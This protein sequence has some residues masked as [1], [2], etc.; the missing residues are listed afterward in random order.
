MATHPNTIHSQILRITHDTKSPLRCIIFICR[1]RTKQSRRIFTPRDNQD[2]QLNGNIHITCASIKL[3]TASAA[4]TE[5]GALFLNAQEARI[6][7]LILLELLHPQPP[8]PVHVDN[9]TVVGIV[10]NAIRCQRSRATE[11]IYFWLLDQKNN[12]Y[13]KVNYQP[14]AE[15]MGDYLSKAH[16]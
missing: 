13:V 1:T 14:G 16:T 4:G 2:I 6:I 8:T 7:R 15:N 12:R 9:T 5:L 3:V 10:N 11:M